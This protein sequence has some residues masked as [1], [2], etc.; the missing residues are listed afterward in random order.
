MTGNWFAS[1][2][3]LTRYVSFNC[4]NSGFVWGFATFGRRTSIYDVHIGGKRWE[5]KESKLYQKIHGIADKRSSV[6]IERSLV[7]F[8]A[9]NLYRVVTEFSAG[10]F[11]KF[12]SVD[13][14]E[15]AKHFYRFGTKEEEAKHFCR[16]W[17]LLEKKIGEEG[18]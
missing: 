4:S 12:C 6:N 1:N 2:I 15:E 14:E 16:I 10:N 13:Q 8:I 7:C 5:H 3:I 17:Q 11:C 9:G 18:T